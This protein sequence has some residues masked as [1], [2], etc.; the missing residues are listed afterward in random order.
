MCKTVYDLTRDEL[1][2]LKESY[3]YQLRD[4]DDE[5]LW[6]LNNPNSQDIDGITAPDQ[7]P[8]SVIFEHYAG[9]S[10]VDDDFFC[11]QK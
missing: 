10:F 3:F 11:N 7:I 5:V 1:D 6:A 4:N 8:D 2:E 9:I